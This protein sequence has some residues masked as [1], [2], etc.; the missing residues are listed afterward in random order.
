MMKR[1]FLMMFVAILAVTLL[2]V[3]ISAEA[4]SAR[5][6]VLI[7]PGHGGSDAGVQVGEKTAEKDVTL[8]V[9]LLMKKALAGGGIDVL[10]TRTADTSLSQADRAKAAASAK[11]DLVLS[12]HVN[13]GFDKKAHGFEV[14]F[15]GF[16]AAAGNGGD[17]KA[18]L[19][20][21]AKNRYLN[22]SVRLARAIEKNLSTV[23]PKANRGLREAPVPLL[24]GLTV[25][26]VVV[27][28]GFATH[29]EDSKRLLEDGTQ[30]AIAAA[31][32]KSIREV[33]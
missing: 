16:Q 29:P 2:S 24:E 19:K 30:Q 23:F 14:W 22:E 12:L 17:S 4:Q 32:A 21:M 13:A 33:L 1:L 28:I 10:L 9:A 31:L 26:A 11:P 25:P 7:D 27:E 6:V 18:I 5:R 8:A 15:P 3:P 20:D